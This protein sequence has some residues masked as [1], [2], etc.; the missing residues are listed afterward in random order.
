[1]MAQSNDIAGVGQE[2]RQAEFCQVFTILADLFV[3]D[4]VVQIEI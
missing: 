3:N 4:K 1:M 2:W